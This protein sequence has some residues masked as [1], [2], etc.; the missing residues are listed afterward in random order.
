VR[1]FIHCGAIVIAALLLGARAPHAQTSD[2]SIPGAANEH[3]SLAASGSF[4]AVAWAATS[5][6]GDPGIFTA[7]SAD[8]ARTFARPVRVATNASVNGEQPPRVA[9]IANRTGLPDIVVVWTAKPGAGT[10]LLTSRSRDGGQTFSAPTV[11]AGSA[12][13]GNRGWESIAVNAAGHPVVLW[14]DHRDSATTSATGGHNHGA[15][16]SSASAAEAS[17]ARAALSRLYVGSTDGGVPTQGLV[18]GVCYCCKTAI[19][20]APDG[21]I[22][23]AWRHVYTGGYRDM[24]FSRSR[25]GGR[26]FSAP[27]RVSQDG[28]QI[29]GCPEDG[30][31]MAVD[32]RGR[33]HIVWPTL[34][35]ENGRETMA[36]FHAVTADGNR[37]SQRTRLP[38]GD[39]AFHPQMVV[40]PGGELVAA[41]DEGSSGTRHVRLARARLTEAGIGG[42]APLEDFREEGHHPALAVVPDGVVIAWTTT[43]DG[44]P[45]EIRVVR[46]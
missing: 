4:L 40:T 44:Q 23:I 24:A 19:A 12:A 41:W 18:H 21:G 1:S 38:A 7:V 11:V 42:F 17:V 22:S 43:R 46:R 9:L 5:S 10:R 34:V 3:V 32:A 39:A 6:G 13:N 33:S 20:T 28:W 16:E 15:P 36:L 14:L 27:V 25:D 30:P 29:A 2:L 26:T 35:R 37:F 31:A 45:S 8:G